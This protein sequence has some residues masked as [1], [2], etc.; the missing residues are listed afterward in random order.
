MLGSRNLSF[1]GIIKIGPRAQ[2]TQ[3]ELTFGLCAV[4]VYRMGGTK[5][6][7]GG[8]G[9][10]GRLRSSFGV[11]QNFTFSRTTLLSF[12]FRVAFF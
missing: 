3:R 8:G 9:E 12:S 4:Q 7:V 1:R 10:G 5:R 11:I 2:G 6:G